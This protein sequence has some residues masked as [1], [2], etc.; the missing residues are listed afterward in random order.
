M[1]DGTPAGMLALM[2]RHLQTVV[3]SGNKHV[4]YLFALGISCSA[5]R[6][7]KVECTVAIFIFFIKRADILEQVS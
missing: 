5:C 4:L 2:T 3:G 7:N 6:Q 1:F